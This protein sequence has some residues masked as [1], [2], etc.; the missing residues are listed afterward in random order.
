V[1]YSI[2]L[3]EG[4]VL[5]DRRRSYGEVLHRLGPMG[6]ANSWSCTSSLRLNEMEL[7][8]AANKA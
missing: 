6:V 2:N 3:S 5:L 1:I 7:S 4:Q 8:G